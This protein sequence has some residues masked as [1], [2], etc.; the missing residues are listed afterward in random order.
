MQVKFTKIFFIGIYKILV[1]SGFRLDR[2]DCI[3]IYED[4]IL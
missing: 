3:F 1:Y 4:D 2:Y